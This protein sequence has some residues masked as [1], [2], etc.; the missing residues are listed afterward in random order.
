MLEE[1]TLK[2]GKL[3]HVSQNDRVKLLSYVQVLQEKTMFI[4]M[5][6]LFIKL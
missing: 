4:P 6:Q 2:T 1:I 5:Y 3:K